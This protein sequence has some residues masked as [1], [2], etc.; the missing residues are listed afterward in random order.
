MG[1]RI[2]PGP[3]KA[4]ATAFVAGE[5]CRGVL[6]LAGSFAR[7]AYGDANP[8]IDETDAGRSIEF[9]HAGIKVVRNVELLVDL[10]SSVRAGNRSRQFPVIRSAT[11]VADGSAATST[12]PGT[13]AS[14]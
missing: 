6:A 12:R 10:V 4:G 9:E 13:D 8:D 5:C 14:S 7:S 3:A 1:E 2:S 11:R